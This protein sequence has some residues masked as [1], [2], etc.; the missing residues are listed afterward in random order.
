MEEREEKREGG[1]RSKGM[2][3]GRGMAIAPELGGEGMK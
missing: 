1:S 3:S 2:V